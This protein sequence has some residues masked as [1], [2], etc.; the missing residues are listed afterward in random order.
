M[1]CLTPPPSD[2]VVTAHC[3]PQRS[4][5]IGTETYCSKRPALVTCF[6]A[7]GDMTPGQV[8]GGDRPAKRQRIAP[9]D[10][11]YGELQAVKHAQR[12]GDALS[13]PALSDALDTFL[14][15]RRISEKAHKGLEAA[16]KN[17][18]TAL[19]AL[20]KKKTM[21]VDS[22]V[23]RNTLRRSAHGRQLDQLFRAD[24]YLDLSLVCRPPTKVNVVGSFL[25]GYSSTPVADVAIE[26]PSELFQSKDYLNYRYHDKRLLY[27]IYLSRH[28]AKTEGD[29]WLNVSLT[30][31]DLNGDEAKPTL[32]VSHVNQPDVVVRL[33]PALAN[34]VFDNGR[35]GDDRRNVRSA[36]DSSI[37]DDPSEATV[38][39]NASILM[40]SS[41]VDNLQVL[42]SVA[43]VA[44]T[45]ADTVLLMDAWCIRHRLITTKFILAAVLAQVIKKGT[46]PPRASREHLLR[47]ALSSIRSGILERLKMNGLRLCAALD[48]AMLYRSKACASAALSVIESNVAAEDPWFGIMPYLF[49]TARGAASAPRPLSTLFDGFVR[50]SMADDGVLPSTEDLLSILKKTFVETRRASHV[51]SLRPGLFG[52]MLISEE[53]MRRKVDMRPDACDVATFKTFWGEKAG[54]RRFK[55]GR[56]VESLVW[57]GGLHTLHEMALFTFEKHLGKAVGVR[58]II[59]DIEEASSSDGQDTSTSNRAIA[60]FDELA[61]VLRSLE[62]LPLSIRAVHGTSAHLRRCGAHSIRPYEVT[63]YTHPLDIVASFE[64]SAAWPEDPVAISAAKAAFYVALKSTLAGKGLHSKATISFLEITLAGFVFRLRIRVDK[65]KKLLPD[66]SE[67][68]DTLVWET[69]TR[70]FHQDKIKHV[71]NPMMGSVARLA[72]RWLN[73]HLLLSQ[74]GVRGEELVEMLVASIMSRPEVSKRNSVM[75]YF[76]QFLHLLGEFPWEVCPLAVFLEDHDKPGPAGDK[77]ERDSEY[78][79]FIECVQQRFSEKADGKMPFAV[80]NSWNEG[81]DDAET[82]FAK[83]YAPERVIADRIV[84][85]ARSSLSFIETHLMAPDCAPSLRTIFATPTDMYDVILDL[86]SQL[87]PFAKG[88]AQKGPFKGRGTPFVG[89][90]PVQMLREELETCLGAFAMFLIE[91]AGRSQIFVVWRPAAESAVTFSLRDAPFREPD[92]DERTLKP[93]REELLAEMRKI[94]NGLIVGTLFP[95]EDG[96]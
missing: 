15:R 34:G 96:H 50:V 79:H 76:C 35:L 25:L 3:E 29:K 55:D 47:C 12:T 40:D 48:P 81:K 56:I 84:A 82:W 59:G 93:C 4:N 5:G 19:D 10:D 26:M 53:S 75:G 1:T 91:Q 51:E 63:R 43:A 90:D 80:Y 95:K 18:K 54:L 20:P 74:M 30:T 64:T 52:I 36:G 21:R 33:I 32:C 89:L 87:T 67:D 71:G 8:H 6:V 41:F 68:R 45:F 28:L 16:L 70:V 9:T 57:T 22:S 17:V 73:A 77:E 49:V 14:S 61:K 2:Y 85:T 83:P 86:D 24:A 60:A 44:P 72:K 46:A 58:V 11:K 69:E 88:S 13:S 92:A 62:G 27:L 38:T 39:Y 7:V 66:F 42:H 37:V 94:G 78:E 65:E 31:A 23:V